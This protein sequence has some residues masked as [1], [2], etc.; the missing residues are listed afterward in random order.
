GSN[1]HVKM[2]DSWFKKKL[3]FSLFR[4]ITKVMFTVLR[5]ATF[6]AVLELFS[7]SFKVISLFSYQ[8]S[9]LSFLATAHLY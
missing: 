2:F 1:S 5:F 7:K 6:V 8:R 9:L 3:G 4:F